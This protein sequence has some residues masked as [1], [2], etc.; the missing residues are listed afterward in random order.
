MNP[1]D[2]VLATDQ[3]VLVDEL[4]SELDPLPKAAAHRQRSLVLLMDPTASLGSTK[5]RLH[6]AETV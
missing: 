6:T 3:H 1:P 2:V 5:V 4:R